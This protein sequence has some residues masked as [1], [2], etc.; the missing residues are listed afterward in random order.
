M[1]LRLLKCYPKKKLHKIKHTRSLLLFLASQDTR[2]LL[3][4]DVGDTGQLFGFHT[5][6]VCMYLYVCMHVYVYSMYVYTNVDVWCVH[7]LHIHVL[8]Y[9]CI[10]MYLC[11]MCMYI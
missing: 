6:C 11:A 7:I 9:T 5:I 2:E 8:T 3:K 1:C 10:Y 4:Y